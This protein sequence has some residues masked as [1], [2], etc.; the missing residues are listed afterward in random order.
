MLFLN[1]Y[2]NLNFHIGSNVCI[3]QIKCWLASLNSKGNAEICITMFYAYKS[4]EL[5]TTQR[6]AW[7]L[8]VSLCYLW[9][10][11]GKFRTYIK[12]KQPADW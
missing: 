1:H 12:T 5:D 7:A 6:T 11:E 8:K 3:S 2:C 9:K 10:L 4:V